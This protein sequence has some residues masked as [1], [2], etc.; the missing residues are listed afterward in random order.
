MSNQY[1]KQVDYRTFIA[2][3]G[4]NERNYTD[5]EATRIFV[6]DL[7][8]WCKETFGNEYETW[9]IDWSGCTFIFDKREDAMAF[10]LRWL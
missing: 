3:A 9:N 7:A 10:K 4:N 5:T 1:V 6:N 2:Y 8:I